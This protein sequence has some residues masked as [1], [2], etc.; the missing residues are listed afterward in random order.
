MNLLPRM[1]SGAKAHDNNFF[2]VYIDFLHATGCND[3][4]NG[5]Q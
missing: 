3:G 4:R 5:L 2:N 1:I